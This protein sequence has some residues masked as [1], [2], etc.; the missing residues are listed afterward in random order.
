MYFKVCEYSI[1]YLHKYYIIQCYKSWK[2]SDKYF[3]QVFFKQSFHK[4]TH[5]QTETDTKFKNMKQEMHRQYFE[6]TFS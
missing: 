4:H 5:T 6:S 1:L 2:Q 3:P